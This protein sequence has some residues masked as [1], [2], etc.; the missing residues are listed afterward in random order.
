VSAPDDKTSN[1]PDGGVGDPAPA[2]IDADPW[3]WFHEA[4]RGSGG[5]TRELANCIAGKIAAPDWLESA[6]SGAVIELR[7]LLKHATAYPT[8][9]ELRT[10]LS[11]VREAAETLATALRDP[12]LIELLTTSS[13]KLGQLRDEGLAQLRATLENRLLHDVSEAGQRI[14]AGK[15][16][17]KHLP[18]PGGLS[19]RELCAAYIAAPYGVGREL[20]GI[21]RRA[22][23]N[24]GSGCDSHTLAAGPDWR[25]RRRGLSEAVLHLHSTDWRR[26]TPVSNGGGDNPHD[27]RGGRTCRPLQSDALLPFMAGPL[28]ALRFPPHLQRPSW[29]R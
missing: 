21:T 10:R 14:R 15:G 29:S 4:V 3:A 13:E 23:G 24:A 7:R 9:D 16:R 11:K 28:S 26:Q 19:P 22:V 5:P 25:S 2:N 12:V 27:Y 6:L 17:D 18:N 8:R 1:T 20:L